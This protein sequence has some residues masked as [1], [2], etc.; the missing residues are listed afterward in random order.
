VKSIL[1]LGC[2]RTAPYKGI[3]KNRCS[4]LVSC[5][6][7]AGPKVDK[8]ADIR[9]LPFADKEFEYV[10]CTETLEHIPQEDQETAFQE[11]LRVGEHGTITFPTPIHPS[12]AKDP[13]HRL[14]T[15]DFGKYP[16]SKHATQ[17]GR[18]IIRW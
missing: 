5:D 1:D 18:V 8:V 12:F 14:V 10:W 3:L 17:T 6:L 13:G 16:V 7:R 15:I 2:G 11:C 4:R 9:K